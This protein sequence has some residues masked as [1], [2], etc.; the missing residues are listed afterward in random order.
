MPDQLPEGWIRLTMGDV[1]RWVGGGTPSKA[2][3]RF[4]TD[5]NIPWVSPKGMK[6]DLITDA[7]DHITED[8]VA[9]SATNLVP[10][11][12]VLIVVRSGIL[13][14]TLPVAVAQR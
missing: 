1:G 5:G 13:Q 4:W 7:Q 8:A 9:Q 12:S 11:G 6:F 10:A 2:N 3:P 14:H